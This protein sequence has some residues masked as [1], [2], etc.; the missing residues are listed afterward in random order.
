MNLQWKMMLLILASTITG[1]LLLISSSIFVGFFFTDG[2]THNDLNRIGNELAGEAE[3]QASDADQ[4]KAKD[5]VESL[6]KRYRQQHSSIQW[7]WF[8]EDGTLQYAT[9]QRSEPY[10]FDQLM[11]RF[12]GMPDKLWGTDEKITLIYK[13]EWINRPQYLIL[14]VSSQA[15]QGT[16]LSLYV[17]QYWMLVYL[18]VPLSLFFITPYIFFFFYFTRMNRRLKKINNAMQELDAKGSNFTIHDQGKDE[19]SQLSRHFNHMSDRIQEQV[20]EIQ[21]HERKRQTLIANL[22]HD[23]RTPLTMIH[24]YAEILHKGMFE[25]EQE[26]QM[27][28]EIILRRAQYMNQL[29]HKLLEVSQLE[30]H[31]EQIHLETVNVSEQ[32]RQLAADYI[33]VL[34]KHGMSFDMHIPD[35]PIITLADLH[36]LDRAVRNLIENAIQYGQ[37][38]KYLRLELTTVQNTVEISVTDHGP[39]IPEEKQEYI[40]QRF[41]RGSE[42]REGEGL[43]IGLA[44]V[45]DIA[46]IHNGSVRLSSTLGK[47]STF[48]LVLPLML[49][50]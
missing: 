9:S 26:R 41:V 24:G 49:D 42:S 40:F 46:T 43:G 17:K 39:G 12:V 18:F 1:I 2:Y 7:E 4:E 48:T 5:Q 30:T 15:M 38:G 20:A 36:L 29:L 23:L 14:S 50:T 8:S 22:S 34:E 21:D 37:S 31:P 16:Q 28:N 3:L 32:L 47:G 45:Q 6:I 19:I 25:N 10:T 35:Q 11:D 33:I 44:I 27:Y 13:W